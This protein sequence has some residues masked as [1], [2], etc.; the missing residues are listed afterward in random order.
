[1]IP[2]G[3]PLTIRDHD[4]GQPT[5]SVIIPAYNHETWIRAAL[6]S[7]LKQTFQNVELI[8][9]NDGSTDG[10]AEKLERFA[11]EETDRFQYFEKENEGVV[12]T[13][14]YALRYVRGDY[15]T[16]LASDDW[17]HPEKL[18][19]Q[20]RLLEGCPH[21]D[22]VFC[23]QYVIDRSGRVVGTRGR[24]APRWIRV[25]GCGPEEPTAPP[26]RWDVAE[27]ILGAVAHPFMP[28]S[29]LAR[30][31]VYRTLNGLDE[32]TELDDI[33]FNLRA[34]LAGFVPR[35]HPELLHS[36]RIHGGNQSS[37]PWWMYTETLSALD[38]FFQ[39]PEVP[40]R[41]G[42]YRRYH[43][44]LQLQ[45][46]AGNLRHGGNTIQALRQYTR[47]LVRFPDRFFL[48]GAEFLGR[49]VHRWISRGGR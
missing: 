23:P 44:A 12:K 47:L 27:L 18:A 25:A 6:D 15:I 3:T 45:I 20:V 43:N 17:I 33:D 34:A 24:L 26:D 37:R 38:R 40:D 13:L 14:N 31:R 32:T 7:V 29:A 1:M 19:V 21:I 42:R 48:S 22:S 5:V 30:A 9:V 35:Y 28:Q 49:Q 2:L 11:R 10:T 36:V 41:L 8:V 39:N 46:L 16:V 4:P